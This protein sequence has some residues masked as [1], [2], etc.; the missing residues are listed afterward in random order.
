MKQK[1]GQLN[2]SFRKTI[3]FYDYKPIPVFNRIRNKFQTITH[4]VHTELIMMSGFVRQSFPPNLSQDLSVTDNIENDAYLKEYHAKYSP[5][6]FL[7]LD[8]ESQLNNKSSLHFLW[9]HGSVIEKNLED[10]E[11]NNIVPEN[12]LICFLTRIVN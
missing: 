9:S 7:D 3:E 12:T 2:D 8:T 1:G 6:Y 10:A 11:G 4:E 5:F